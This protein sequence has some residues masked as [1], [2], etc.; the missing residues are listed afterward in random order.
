MILEFTSSSGTSLLIF[1]NSE[2]FD[3]TLLYISCS[4]S[5]KELS[6]MWSGN[7]IFLITV[8]KITH[9]SAAL[10]KD[11]NASYNADQ[12]NA[13]AQTIPAITLIIRQ[14]LFI[15]DFISQIILII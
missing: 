7:T 4:I 12:N 15:R 14:I 8:P 13:L 2:E 10:Q 9:G 1:D 3:N 11:H 5:S 6:I